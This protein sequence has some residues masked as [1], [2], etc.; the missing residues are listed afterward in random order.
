MLEAGG[1]DR[2]P[3]VALPVGIALAYKNLNWHYAVEPDASRGGIVE[4][5]PAGKVLGGGGSINAGVFVRGNIA[6]YDNWAQLG[7]DG[8]DYRSVLPLFRRL[9]NW[10]GGADEFRGTG[11]PI[12]VRWHRVPHVANDAFIAAAQQAGYPFNHDYN[13][14]TQDGVG[15]S[16]V[17]QRGHFRSQSS[18][19]YLHRLASAKALTVHTRAFAERI[20]FDGERA[21]GVEYLQGGVRRTVRAS[22]EIVLSAGTIGTPKLLLLSG[23]GPAE[24]LRRVGIAVVH[25]SQ[26]VGRG[27]HE[28]PCIFLRYAAQ[29]PNLNTMGPREALKGLASYAVSGGGFLASTM[30]HAQV[31]HRTDSGLPVPDIQIC[32]ANFGTVRQLAPNGDV[33][34]SVPREGS[35]LVTMMF[36][37]PTPRGSVR[38][39][40]ASAA[41]PPR[42]SYE[43][44][45]DKS[46]LGA[47]L[48]GIEETQRIMSQPALR[49]I[50]GALSGPEVSNRTP[51]HW[52]AW[53][54]SNLHGGAHP[55]GTARMGVDDGAVV[56]P[57]L[58]V[59]G[60]TGLRVADASVM[61][62]I[63]NGNT[64]AP[65]MMIGE[66]AAD[67][68]MQPV[69]AA[70]ASGRP[71]HHN[72]KGAS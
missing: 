16:Q 40:S 43:M 18:R 63:T 3:E 35:F 49:G 64:N 72:S 60:V 39:R 5:W 19:E 55:V 17:N 56:D 15:V 47:I 21:V 67:L 26:G 28:H 24:E 65:S 34:V 61:P 42:I 14:A 25:D 57:Q 12:G 62:R 66:K 13:G 32:F 71:I 30:G 36:T 41:D 31:M 70:T 20:L 58:R 68:I 1:T 54:R 23:I 4:K 2:R 37:R 46:D 7:N 11:G 53:L 22:E 59:H 27:L 44:L 10:E 38:L 45:D 9:E 33:K 69:P 8:W 50:S 48:A 51:E 29:V 6:D 52:E